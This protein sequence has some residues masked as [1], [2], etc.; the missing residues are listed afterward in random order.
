[1]KKPKLK[2]PKLKKP[3]LKLNKTMPRVW[4]RQKTPKAQKCRQGSSILPDG[5]QVNVSSSLGTA[6]TPALALVLGAKGH[7]AATAGHV[8]AAATL[9]L[10]VGC[11]CRGLELSDP[12]CLEGGFLRVGR[13]GDRL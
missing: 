7:G 3:K 9:G 2:K 11:I 12:I 13:V 5:L 4:M 8:Q 10:A 6:D 1:V